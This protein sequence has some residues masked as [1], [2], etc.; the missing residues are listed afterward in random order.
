MKASYA[1]ISIINKFTA[2]FKELFSNKQFVAFDAFIQAMLYDYK[3]VNL[4][5]LSKEQSIP[6]QQ[7]QYFFSE[8]GW[9]YQKLNTARIDVL[10]RQR[11]TSFTKNGVLAIDDTG[12]YKPYA[13][14]TEGTG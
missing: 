14:K 1:N 6:Y 8:S 12:S 3:R 7:L 5:A 13:K 4:F 9:D 11:T 2:N 10:K